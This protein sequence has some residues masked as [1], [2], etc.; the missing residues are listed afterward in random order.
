METFGP[1]LLGLLVAAG[2]LVPL[3]LTARSRAA[4][5]TAE[6]DALELELGGLKKSKA[7]LEADQGF[8]TQFMKDFPHLA[9][10][11]FTGL[12]ERQVPLSMLHVIQK[13]F[14]PAQAV[15]LV[16]R[17]HGEGDLKDRRF[18]V[19]AVVPE[20]GLI[21]LGAE[22]PIA[23]GE[24]G[25]AAESQL[26]VSRQDL[27][28][29]NAK[30]R[31]KPGPNPLSAFTPELFAPLVFDQETLGLVA[32]SKPRKTSGDVKAA[33]RLI[34]QTGAQALHNAAAYTQ[35]KV[36]AEMD[37]LTRIFNKK[38]MEQALSEIVY[39]TA[40]EAYDRRDQG[41]TTAAQTLSVFLFDIDNF[42]H[43]NDTNGHLAG[44]KLLQE[45]AHLVPQTIRKDDI[46]GRFGGEEFLVI[47]PNTNLAQGLAAANK[48]RAIVAAHPFP[49]A[50]KQP[51]QALS[52]S[53]GVAEYPYHGRDAQSLLHAAD[54]A[55]YEAKR[56][57]RNRVAAAATAKV[58]TPEPLPQN[59]GRPAPAQGPGEARSA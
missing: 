16:R 20:A 17:G 27:E 41:G 46:F 7:Q 21:H 43:Y 37:G 55:L 28:E 34:A 47:L 57:G 42:K 9:R 40:C 54:E 2:V 52:V 10:D 6:A 12:K 29:G 15:V 59:P 14:D 33:L 3:L 8:L 26:V 18:V 5:M 39:R 38:H 4:E 50:E 58:A 23:T 30:S 44:D 36:T 24:I 11:L 49:F 1:F 56:Q 48:V 53:G 35:I 19:A 25:F 31:I 13:S 45:L 32:L 22:V 51:F